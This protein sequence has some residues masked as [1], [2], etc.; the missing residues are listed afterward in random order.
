MEQYIPKAA[1]VAEIKRRIENLY[2]REGQGIIVT[3]ILKEHYEDFLSFLDTLKVKEV[4]LDREIEKCLKQYH[5]L[6]VGK[7]DFAPIAKHFFE[8]GLKAKKRDN[9]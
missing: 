8:L 6:A 1:V 5:M 2:P 4:D 7:K 3:K 9:E